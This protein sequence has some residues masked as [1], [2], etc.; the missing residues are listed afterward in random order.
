M[1]KPK[2]IRNNTCHQMI[3]KTGTFVVKQSAALPPTKNIDLCAYL[4]RSFSLFV[5][6]PEIESSITIWLHLLNE[7]H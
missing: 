4:L 3:F 7:L 2:I 1:A 5:S 6:L